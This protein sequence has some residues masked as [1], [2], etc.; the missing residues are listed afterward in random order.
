MEAAKAQN[1]A[2]E[3]QEE[4]NGYRKYNNTVKK[5]KISATYSYFST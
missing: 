3:P 2:V 1:W 4:N 5:S